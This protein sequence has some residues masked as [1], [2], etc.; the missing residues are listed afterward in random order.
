MPQPEPLSE[1]GE[2]FATRFGELLKIAATNP[3]PKEP[4]LVPAAGERSLL[5][6]EGIAA[7]KDVEIVLVRAKHDANGKPLAVKETLTYRK[8]IAGS[9]LVYDL[10]GQFMQGK[11]RPFDCDLRNQ[12]AR[13][14]A[15][16]PFQ[17]DNFSVDAKQQ[18]DE[19]AIEVEFQ[20][21]LGKRVEGSL[22][23]H[24]QLRTPDGKVAWERYLATYPEGKLTATADLPPKGPHGKWSL[25]VRS[26]LDGKEVTLSLEVGPKT[27]K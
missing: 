10:T 17:V 12:P 13:L 9:D 8:D 16:L 11:A 7:S 21:A 5:T 14:Y 23:C 6:C 25:V 27:G 1:L 18:Q 3:K 2:D 4:A 15:L 19:I 24:A 20:N 22:P 26:Q